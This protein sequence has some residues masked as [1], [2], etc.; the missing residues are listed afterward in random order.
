M[1]SHYSEEEMVAAIRSGGRAM[2]QVMRYIY[3]QADYR[4]EVLRM[5]LAKQGS[6]EDAEDV[7]Q[8]GIAHLIMNVR[9]GKFRGESSLKTYLT[10][11]CKNLWFYK[12]NRRVKLQSIKTELPTNELDEESPEQLLLFKEKTERVKQL[13][14][15]LGSPCQEILT[16]WSLHYS[17]K[18]IAVR[19]GYKNEGTMR[20][21]K[22]QCMQKLIKLV[23]GKF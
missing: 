3:E 6:V 19:T 4:E 9:K 13:L 15:Q 18:E 11:I 14:A 16:L 5:V 12:F 2:E 7:F 23:K 17:M 8:D 20:K 1:R 10:V 22:H 21:K